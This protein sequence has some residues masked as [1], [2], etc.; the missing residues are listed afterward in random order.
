MTT[1]LARRTDPI[2]SHIAAADHVQS[3]ANDK[4][5]FLVLTFL[6]RYVA[7]L[8][9]YPTSAELADKY[10][11]DRHMVA[12]RLPDLEREGLVAKDECMGQL[13]K[14]KCTVNGTTAC[15]WKVL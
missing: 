10:G 5:K 15:I 6:R 13:T 11:M 8:N 9:R 3:G 1:T 7:S 14:R 12:K 2:T 4:Q